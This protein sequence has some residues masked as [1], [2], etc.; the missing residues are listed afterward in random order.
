MI[1]VCL[2]KQLPFREL[3]QGNG[4][5]QQ[6]FVASPELLSV[7]NGEKRLRV[8]CLGSPRS[9][10]QSARRWLLRPSLSF[11]IN[12]ICI[13]DSNFIVWLSRKRVNSA[14]FNSDHTQPQAEEFQILGATQGVVWV[15]SSQAQES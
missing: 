5:D 14:E 1:C 13:I 10:V 2:S 9:L 3:W 15:Q 4:C 11:D 8:C 12:A 7:A 6:T